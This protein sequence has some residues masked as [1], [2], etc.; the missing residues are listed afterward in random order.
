V[1]V[2]DLACCLEAGREGG[3][4]GQIKRQ[5][6]LV[7]GLRTAGLELEYFPPTW[8]GRHQ[9]VYGASPDAFAIV[10]SYWHFVP[11]MPPQSA[12]ERLGQ[13]HL[14]HDQKSGVDQPIPIGTDPPIVAA[15]KAL[16][17]VPKSGPIEG[18]AERI[19]FEEAMDE[20]AEPAGI[21]PIDKR[22]LGREHRAS[23]SGTD[24]YARRRRRG[25]QAR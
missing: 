2:D 25:R 20:G 23:A 15:K 19:V 3:D 17:Q 21:G 14:P 18:A 6:G 9:G 5:L 16:G 10:E 7:P 24:F 4:G 22:L 12:D 8:T 13:G 1:Q 11:A